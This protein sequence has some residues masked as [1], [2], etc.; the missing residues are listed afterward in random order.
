MLLFC[1]GWKIDQTMMEIFQSCWP[2]LEKLHTIKYVLLAVEGVL[3]MV[4]Q[5]YLSGL[6]VVFQDQLL[7]SGQVVGC[8]E[9]FMTI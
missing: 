5:I 4:P 2:P 7:A 9:P 6:L 3:F 8:Q 1:A